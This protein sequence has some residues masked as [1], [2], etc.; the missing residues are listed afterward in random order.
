MQEL[1][2]KASVDKD[3]ILLI[4]AFDL[5]AIDENGSYAIG[6][7]IN[8]VDYDSD[9][10]FT[11]VAIKTDEDSYTVRSAGDIYEKEGY[12]LIVYEAEVPAGTNEYYIRGYV[13]NG[14]DIVSSTTRLYA[15]VTK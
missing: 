12:A 14:G 10:Y 5:S 8:G 13:K 15:T 9:T 4:C 1:K 2:G 7:T 3:Y 11:S 6:F